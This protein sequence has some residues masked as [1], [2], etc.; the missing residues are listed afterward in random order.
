MNTLKNIPPP[1]ATL[2][3]L[4]LSC[5]SGHLDPIVLDSF[6]VNLWYSG[7]PRTPNLLKISSDIESGFRMAFSAH[8]TLIWKLNQIS[9]T[10]INKVTCKCIWCCHWVQRCVTSP[11]IGVKLCSGAWK[12]GQNSH[13]GTFSLWYIGMD[14]WLHPTDKLLNVIIHPFPNLRQSMVTEQAISYCLCQTV[15]HHREIIW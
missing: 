10:I 5:L 7:V 6:D 9:M 14:K 4:V 12:R 8:C 15:F 3:N 11:D 1:L 2:P 13:V